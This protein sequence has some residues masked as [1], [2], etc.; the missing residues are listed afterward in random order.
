MQV[1]HRLFL[2]SFL[3]FLI[4]VAKQ[5]PMVLAEGNGVA[6]GAC[7]STGELDMG[8]SIVMGVPHSWMV[9]HGKSY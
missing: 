2:G 8:V 3:L 4:L 6:G 7:P 1:F 5:G 9:Y